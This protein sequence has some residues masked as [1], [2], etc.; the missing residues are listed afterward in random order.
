[1]F[2]GDQSSLFIDF[3]GDIPKQILSF[4]SVNDTNISDLSDV[5]TNNPAVPVFILL[6]T[7]DQVFKLDSAPSL[8]PILFKKILNRRFKKNFKETD[9]KRTYIVDKNKSEKVTSFVM[10]DIA[11]D[12]PLSDW[13]DFITNIGGHL[14][15]V[16]SFPYEVQGIYQ[17]IEKYLAKNQKYIKKSKWKML[18]IHNKTGGFR[19]IVIKDNRLVFTR[20]IHSNQGGEYDAEKITILQNQIIGT[21][22]YLRRLNFKEK[23]GINIY[24]ILDEKLRQFFDNNNMRNYHSHFVAVNELA[25]AFH[26]GDSNHAN[27]SE[28]VLSAYFFKKGKYLAFLTDKMKERYVLYN[29]NISLSFVTLF[30][31]FGVALYGLIGLHSESEY[32]KK[33]NILGFKAKKEVSQFDDLRNKK[34][35]VHGNAD[36]VI[37]VVTLHR[38]L[39]SEKRDPN[40]RIVEFIKI[41]PRNVNVKSIYWSEKENIETLEISAVLDS[42]NL[43]YEALFQNYDSFIR[44]VKKQFAQYDVVH[45]DLPETISFD[46]DVES[47]DL[48]ITITGPKKAEK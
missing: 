38:V 17:A 43:S 34:F 23:Q 46:K 19:Q 10:I 5:I 21:I 8:N 11:M 2:V 32:T 40:D 18:V 29:L 25:T 48:E 3:E 7:G 47:V 41:K 13:I 27:L 20:L 24:F 26:W 35:G 22:E 28:A 14:I 33:M 15:G 44:Q 30:V 6:D 12:P 45:S 36:R 9:L 1:M 39:I 16:Y 4:S 42:N 37:D 31:F